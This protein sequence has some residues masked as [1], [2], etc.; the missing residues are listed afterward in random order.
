MSNFRLRKNINNP[1]PVTS[2]RRMFVDLG[3][4][5]TAWARRWSDLILAHAGD[6]GGVEMISEAQLSICRRASA[7]ECELESM[8]GKMSAGQ[9]I[10]IA[11]Y[12][13]LVG[14]L[15]RLF[16]LIG[17]KGRVKLDPQTALARALAGYPATV[18]DED[19][20]DD[21]PL[22]PAA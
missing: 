22:P 15:A 8:E 9:P 14:V 17:V 13:R 12:A 10:E 7:I 19:A 2:G 4:G 16:E 3:D 18:L 1:S 11:V 21:E 20:D 5:R 6:L